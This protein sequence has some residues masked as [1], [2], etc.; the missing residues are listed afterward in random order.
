MPFF[1]VTDQRFLLVLV[2]VQGVTQML[3]QARPEQLTGGSTDSDHGYSIT[4]AHF[5]DRPQMRLFGGDAEESEAF[6]RSLTHLATNGT[7][8]D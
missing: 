1:V 5:R 6:A 2:Q 8:P 3:D 4:I 7:L